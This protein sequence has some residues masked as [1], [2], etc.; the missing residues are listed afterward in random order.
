MSQSQNTD[1]SAFSPSSRRTHSKINQNT[2]S[3]EQKKIFKNINCNNKNSVISAWTAFRN[4]Y[5]NCYIIG[6]FT[7]NLNK[8]AT[9][10]AS[11]IHIRDD[12]IW[13]ELR[14]ASVTKTE[15]MQT[16]YDYK[17]NKII[18]TIGVPRRIINA[19]CN[20][21]IV[22]WQFDPK[23][24]LA[25][26][27]RALKD[28]P[29]TNPNKEKHQK[30]QTQTDKNKQPQTNK[31]S[32]SKYEEDS[33][34][35]IKEHESKK[36]RTVI[37]LKKNIR[38]EN[39]ASFSQ[40]AS[41]QPKNV[42]L[43]K[44]HISA[45]RM[46]FESNIAT[47]KLLDENE[48][49]EH[50]QSLANM[51]EKVK[52]ENKK[53]KINNN[54][55]YIIIK[56]IDTTAA[57][58]WQLDFEV[59]AEMTSLLEV[60]QNANQRTKLSEIDW[61]SDIFSTEYDKDQ[62][63]LKIIFNKNSEW[64]A[65]N[66]NWREIWHSDFPKDGTNFGDQLHIECVKKQIIVKKYVFAGVPTKYMDNYGWG[67]KYH[68]MKRHNIANEDILN[69]QIWGKKY[70]NIATVQFK[71]V[72]INGN[73]M[74]F[75]L[76]NYCKITPYNT[77]LS[78]KED[79]KAKEVRFCEHC[80]KIGHTQQQC[81]IYKKYYNEHK[82]QIEKQPRISKQ[83]IDNEIKNI[84]VNLPNSHRRCKNCGEWGHIKSECNNPKKCTVCN[85]TEHS[86]ENY[87]K[88]LKWTNAIG[89]TQLKKKQEK[90]KNEKKKKEKQKNEKKNEKKQQ[91]ENEKKQQMANETENEEKE[92]IEEKEKTKDQITTESNVEG[93]KN[94]SDE[95]DDD[96]TDLQ[97]SRMTINFD[98]DV[99][100]DSENENDNETAL[101]QSQ[102]INI[103][104]GKPIMQK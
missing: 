14:N 64:I 70:P 92:I 46:F 27:Q 99:G 25:K 61:H 29:H 100:F 37:R 57:I 97:S 66:P 24:K 23:S 16:A 6:S 32:R 58:A 17:Q 93:D 38:K 40:I 31:R 2:L 49:K 98:K 43:H 22:D 15:Q 90:K 55:D 68:L 35:Q 91:K 26:Y 41:S 21:Q 54:I 4:K 86:C 65:K 48:T 52:Y 45:K 74:Y 76:N 8:E 47:C 73:Y 28:K 89:F 75:G 78:Y 50:T 60:L 94:S 10:F 1:Q 5:K 87:D 12:K 20:F 19:I 3:N 56:N 72:E 85:S 9:G 51:F 44:E 71:N 34:E 95:E 42:Q 67:L 102:V 101:N 30:T 84:P 96:Y 79:K 82:Q 81:R 13:K 63:T 104:M 77:K 80:L 18:T 11:H 53:S 62:H 69:I 39:D 88:C 36:Q 103:D 33:K 83:E 59:Q 7:H